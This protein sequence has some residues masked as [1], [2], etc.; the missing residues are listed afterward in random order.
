MNVR[1]IRTSKSALILL[2]P[3]LFFT[4]LLWDTPTTAETI[5]TINPKQAA[6]LVLRENGN[7]D[8]I[9]LDIRTPAEFQAGHLNG[10]VLLDYY[11]KTFVEGLK[12]LDRN[13]IYLVYCRSGNRS[14]KALSLFKHLE[15]KQVY[16]IAQGING[17]V[18]AGLPII[19]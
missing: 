12:Q 13:K 17:W 4:L 6:E 10:A 8:F 19:S 15:F 11:S 18:K 2:M 14:G 3:L 1:K 5:Q 16:N 7:T 9:I